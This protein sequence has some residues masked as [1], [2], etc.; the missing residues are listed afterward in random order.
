VRDDF[1][2]AARCGGNTVEHVPALEYAAPRRVADRVSDLRYA[3]T[4]TGAEHIGEASG[5]ERL[6]VSLG[7][8]PA[9]GGAPRARYR[10]TTCAALIAC[11][12]AAC[13]L[14]E[15]GV[16]PGAVDGARIAAAVEDLHPVH[17]NR[18]DLV[19]LAL[20]RALAGR[21]SPRGAAP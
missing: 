14:V 17:R 21:S 8:W 12:E 7:L 1:S 2:L 15:A 3:G 6:L 5:G 11:A 19:A 20:S 10:C 13:A 18:A 9:D 4:L 16:E